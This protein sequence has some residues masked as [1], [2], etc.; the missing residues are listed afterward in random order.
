M[1]RLTR[2]AP[3]I[4][5]MPR[6]DAMREIPRLLGIEPSDM[7]ARAA[8]IPEGIHAG[9]VMRAGAD[10][11]RAAGGGSVPVLDDLRRAIAA[12]PPER[13]GLPLLVS[14]GRLAAAKGMD[15]IVAAWAGDAQLHASTNLVIVGGDLERPSPEESETLAAIDAAL[16]GRPGAADGL[17]LLGH[18]P[19]LDAMRV[20][21]HAAR[22]GGVYVCGS[23]KEEY[24]LAIVEGLGAGLVAVAPEVGGPATYIDGANGVLV[25][26]TRVEA[27]RAGIHRALALAPV[28]GRAEA[29][30]ATVLGEMTIE[31]M[32]DRLVELYGRIVPG[33]AVSAPTATEA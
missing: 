5:V 3:G 29:T 13:H 8:V 9:T 26:A 25:D 22:G 10:A 16:G 21:G 2:E 32:A 33:V 7:A 31:R 4:A 20:L 1:E 14:V 19:H 27:L 6:A 30:R 15:R 17:V 28:P 18:R 23:E 24:G 11:A 12:M